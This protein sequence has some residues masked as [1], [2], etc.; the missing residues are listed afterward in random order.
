MVS[1][2]FFPTT[3]RPYR[4]CKPVCVCV[5]GR[6]W[7]KKKWQ[8]HNTQQGG[9]FVLLSL[10]TL[11]WSICQVNE[12]TAAWQSVP[13]KPAMI[14]HHTCERTREE[15]QDTANQKQTSHPGKVSMNLEQT[16]LTPSKGKISRL[17]RCSE[18]SWKGRG[19]MI[20]EAD[21]ERVCWKFWSNAGGYA[22][23]GDYRPKYSMI[24]NN[25]N[26][27]SSKL[28]VSF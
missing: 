16:L 19:R 7:L 10:E 20:D 25:L 23:F 14:K 28:E 6:Y 3:L 22:V 5:A 26:L 9:P 15:S 17:D 2:L 1:D 11:S 21:A 8:P 18:E 4:L 13:S 27:Q 12:Q 24:D